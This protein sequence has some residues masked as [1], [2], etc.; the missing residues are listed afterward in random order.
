MPLV[1]SGRLLKTCTAAIKVTTIPI[2]FHRPS[3]V[4]IIQIAIPS[5]NPSSSNKIR[6]SPEVCTMKT[7]M[8]QRAVAIIGKAKNCLSVSIQAPG[9]GRALIH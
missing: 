5:I 4:A 8:S 9:C 7:H 3:N 2:H 1:F 6:A